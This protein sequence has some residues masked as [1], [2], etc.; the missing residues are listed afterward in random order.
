[1]YSWVG[2]KAVEKLNLYIR[3][4]GLIV[5]TGQLTTEKEIFRMQMSLTIKGFYFFSPNRMFNP[6]NLVSK[7]NFTLSLFTLFIDVPIP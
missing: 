7:V 5:S 3:A 6:S 4:F 2:N 1:M